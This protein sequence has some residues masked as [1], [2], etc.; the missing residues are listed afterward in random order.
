V[1][2]VSLLLAAGLV[3]SGLCGCQVERRKSDAEL[4]LNATQAA[5]R[6]FFDRQCGGCHEA[7]SSHPRKGPSLQGLFKHPYLKNGMRAN[8]ERVREI[9]VFGRAMMPAFRRTLSAQQVDEL[10]EYLHTL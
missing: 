4:G 1:L 8:D 2:Y 6:Q 9:V 5:G 10:M 7:Y 3:L